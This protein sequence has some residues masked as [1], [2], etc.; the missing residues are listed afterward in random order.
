M[1]TLKI[2]SKSNPNM[3][4]GA[5]VNVLKVNKSVEMHTIG[6]GALNQCVKAIAIARGYLMPCG[7]DLMCK[8]SFLEIEVSGEIKTGIKLVVTRE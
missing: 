1:E 7:E 4:A 6:A 2:S 3:V 5:L 8:P